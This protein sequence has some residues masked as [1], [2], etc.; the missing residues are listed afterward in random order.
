MAE[1][2]ESVLL[3]TDHVVGARSISDLGAEADDDVLDQLWSQLQRAHAAGLAHG[4]I[5]A[6][7]VG[8]DES[9]RLWLLDWASGETISTELSRRVDLA[10][11][12][13]LTAD[14]DEDT[15]DFTPNYDYT[16]TEPEVLPAAFP[17][18][19]VNGAAG[20]AVGMA[21]NMPPHNLVEVV[22]AARHLNQHLGQHL[23]LP[24]GLPRRLPLPS[25]AQESSPADPR[26]RLR[27]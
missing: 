23:S 4:S 2:A 27:P 6:S 1:A 5:D 18:L 13:A 16:L 14:L 8:V 7:S 17:N 3:V 19:L 20:I 26:R 9:G 10:Q 24:P 15:V 12:L 25:P 21:T 11:A 22:A